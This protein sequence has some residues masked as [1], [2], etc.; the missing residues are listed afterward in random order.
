MSNVP[1]KSI[2]KRTRERA[3]SWCFTWNR[4]GTNDVLRL[5]QLGR[6][7]DGIVYLIY[8]RENC[9][10]T[11]ARHLQGYITFTNPRDMGGV[12]QLLSNQTVHLEKAKGTGI[13]NRQYCS[14]DG[15]FEEYGQLPQPGQ[16]SDLLQI[17]DRIIA[18]ETEKVI[19]M[20]HFT[21]WVVYRRSF[22]E[23]KS[24]VSKPELRKELE[25]FC[26]YGEAG[27]GKTQFVWDYC[28]DHGRELFFVCDV[29]LDWFDG[30]RGELD[31]LIDD[32]RGGGTLAFLLRLLDKYPLQVPIKGGFVQWLPIR[33]W[34]TSNLH[35]TEWF[36]GLDQESTAAL[37]RRISRDAHVVRRN[38]DFNKTRD[39]IKKDLGLE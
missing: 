32:Y 35:Y 28:R 1:K 33:I 11:G 17:R 10:T 27:S 3:R 18:G 25:V 34:L 30:Y 7:L 29:K 38:G 22:T 2:R 14:K 6:A 31:V 15:D 39:L 37:T 26:L 19:A 21:Q 13:Q 36:S 24:L 9:P 12:K 4:F 23:F 16:R 20:E 5:R 8:G